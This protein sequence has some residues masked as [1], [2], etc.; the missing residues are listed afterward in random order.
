[1]L[2][3]T[4]KHVMIPIDKNYYDQ[5]RLVKYSYKVSDD[6]RDVTINGK[7]KIELRI[8]SL[9]KESSDAIAYGTNSQLYL[10]KGETSG[11]ISKLGGPI[12]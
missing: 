4:S 12:V 11:E 9:T 5:A 3:G 7:V 2:G 10:D 1:M 6:G 8:C